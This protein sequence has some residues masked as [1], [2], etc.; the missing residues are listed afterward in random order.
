[1]SG[2]ACPHFPACFLFRKETPILCRDLLE[3]C[4]AFRELFQNLRKKEEKAKQNEK[5]LKGI[6][7]SY[8]PHPAANGIKKNDASDHKG[9]GQ[10]VPAQ[11]KKK[12][13]SHGKD[14]RSQ[15]SDISGEE[16]NGAVNA[17]FFPVM[18]FQNIGYGKK[19]HFPQVFNIKKPPQQQGKC[20]S[21][22]IGDHSVK[23][24]GVH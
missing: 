4:Q 12:D 1:M 16:K 7:K 11:K 3:K 20:G 23:S 17:G 18:D 8:R 6:G 15:P 13:L 9:A 2:A 5:E 21:E 19:F 14:Q 10:R 24:F 22:R